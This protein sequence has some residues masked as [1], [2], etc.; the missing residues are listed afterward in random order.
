MDFSFSDEQKNIRQLAAKAFANS[1][2]GNAQSQWTELVR[3]GLTGVAIPTECGGSGLGF[4]EL[5]CLF[6]EA[7]RAASSTPL[8]P[9][10]L[11]AMALDHCGERALLPAIAEGKKLAVALSEPAGNHPLR[12]ATYAEAQNSGWRL[13]GEKTCVAAADEA[14]SILVSARAS[15]RVALFAIDPSSPG[16]KIERQIATDDSAIFQVTLSNASAKQIGD[17]DAVTWLS[18]RL[19]TGYAAVALG[20]AERQVEMIGR[21]VVERR[22]FDK[23]IGAFQA[24]AQRAADAYIDVEAMRLSLW[25]AAFKL[26]TTADAPSES[27]VAGFWAAE[28]GQRVAVAAQHL[29]GGVGFDRAYPLHRYF[30]LAKQIELQL[31]GATCQLAELGKIQCRTN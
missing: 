7:G 5:C 8:V 6:V 11:G 26:A 4:L 25:Q 16:C 31:G 3:A 17:A 30:L 21:Y 18:E 23:P 29:H 10:L 1:Q 24:V 13:F 12:P 14:V 22:Q 2:A 20:I 15:D 9:S 19:R 27:L 28:A